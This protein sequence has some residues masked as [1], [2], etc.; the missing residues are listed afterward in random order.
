MSTRWFA[1][2]RARSVPA[3]RAQSLI[4]FALILPLFLLLTLGVL[5][6][7]RTFTAKIALTNGVRQAAIFASAGDYDAWCSS[8]VGFNAIPCPAGANGHTDLG[9][10]P[11]DSVAYRIQVEAAGMDPAAIVLSAPTCAASASVGATFGPC[12]DQSQVVK[13]SASYDLP[14]LTPLL[15][16]IIGGQLHLQAVTVAQVQR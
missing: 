4:E 7:A 15:G 2:P 13:I 9:T 3:H 1:A 6:L 16:A 14:V 10:D 12:T 11:W 8:S 5:D